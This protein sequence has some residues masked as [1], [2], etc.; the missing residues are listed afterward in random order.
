ME[1]KNFIML[2]AAATFFLSTF[3]VPSARAAS[4]AECAIWLCLPGGFPSGCSAAHSEFKKR[5]KKGKPPLPDL[6]SCTTGPDGKGS[7]GSYQLGYELFEACKTGYVLRQNQNGYMSTGTCE[8]P[9]C[10]SH[11]GFGNYNGNVCDRYAAV[12]RTQPSYV[13]MWVDGK[14]IGQYWY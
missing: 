5:I 3:Y 6:S 1:L 7:S 12:R 9:Q 14:Y 11:Y 2:S 13:K 10:H 4:E 8:K